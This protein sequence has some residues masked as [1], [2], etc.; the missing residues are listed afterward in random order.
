M[1]DVIKTASTASGGE[2]EGV[3]TD[4]QSDLGG[5]FPPGFLKVVGLLIPTAAP[6]SELVDWYENEHSRAAMFLWPYMDRYARNY[7]LEVE[8]GSLPP[9][10]VVTEFV[11]KGEGAKRKG[12]ALFDT[13][14]VQPLN[15]EMTRNRLRLQLPFPPGVMF[16]VPAEPHTVRELPAADIDAPS[17][18]GRVMLLRSAPGS[19]RAVFDA[20]V[21]DLA[22]R[23]AQ[24][25]PEAGVSFDLLRPS[26]MTPAPADAVIF[27]RT[28]RTAALP[29]PEPQGM[30]VINVFSVETRKSP[31]DEAGPPA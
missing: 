11:W 13:P 18:R 5:L 19:S 1:G 8:E 12:R 24:T 17:V 7:I 14:A 6:L 29:R 23:I 3:Q 20:A 31:L 9:Y 27:V 25:W 21:E 30:D 15:D 26:A 2:P 28:D 10:R 4:D 22:L 16:M